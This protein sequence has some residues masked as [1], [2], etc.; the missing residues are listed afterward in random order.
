MAFQNM[1]SKPMSL[2][3][4]NHNYTGNILLGKCFYSTLKYLDCDIFSFYT[5]FQE[6][7]FVYHVYT[8]LFSPPKFPGDEPSTQLV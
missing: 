4:P 2:A 7:S 6:G 5:E 3:M 1:R 8:P